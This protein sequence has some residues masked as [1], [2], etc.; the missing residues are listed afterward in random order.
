MIRFLSHNKIMATHATSFNKINQDTPNVEIQ[1]CA[2]CEWS[3]GR[4]VGV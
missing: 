1:A 3:Q 2:L 4:G